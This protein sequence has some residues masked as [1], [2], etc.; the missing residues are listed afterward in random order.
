MQLA[1][2]DRNETRLLESN[3]KIVSGLRF[4]RGPGIGHAAKPR[5]QRRATETAALQLRLRLAADP[6]AGAYEV[7]IALSEID[8][9]VEVL[10]VDLRR[11]V[12]TAADKCAARLRELGYVVTSAEV[13]GALEEAITESDVAQRAVAA[14]N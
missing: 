2:V 7:T 9:V 4:A 13:L 12:R 5:V 14:P 1:H 10:D 8:V 11:A 6:A 3:G